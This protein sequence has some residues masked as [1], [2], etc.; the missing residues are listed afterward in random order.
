[1]KSIPIKTEYIKPN[2]GYAKLVNLIS[3]KC[4]DGDII[5]VSETP[6]STAEG[7]LIDESKYNHGILAYL[8]CDIWSKYLWGYVLAPILGYKKRTIQNLRRM[9]KKARAHK[10][11]IYEKYGLKH[12]LQ[13]TSEAGV[14]LSNVPGEY[15]SPL[16]ENPDRSAKK[17]KEEIYKKSNKNV[18]VIIIDT[19]PTYEFKGK[20]FTTLPKALAEIKTDMGI[21]GYLMQI[22]S[23]KR[24]ATILATTQ[25]EYD[26]DKL[27]EMANIA[28]DVQRNAS[29]NFFE[30]I[31][32][33]QDEFNTDK[34]TEDML[35]KVT[36]IPAIILR[37][38]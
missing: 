37:Y 23:K 22:V 18:D 38:L 12:A 36:H 6:I 3:T 30:T 19:D 32:N 17:L 27:I 16:P 31:Y 35:L 4:I 26:I 1:M 28:E 7:N 20:L 25:N 15:V 2:E 8:L 5:I 9:P 29:D 13:P 14:D 21:Y 11:L 33:M 34:I 10:Q 24:G